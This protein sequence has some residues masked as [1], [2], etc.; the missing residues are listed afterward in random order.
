MSKDLRYFLKEVE[1]KQPEDFVRIKK[2]VDPKFELCGVIR[3]FQEEGRYPLVYFENVKNSEMP[4]VSNLFA[5]KSRL[6][7]GFGASE[8]TL[9][10]D[11]MT[12]EDK[13]IPSK[14]VSDGP[15][16]ENV[17]KGDDSISEILASHYSL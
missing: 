16:K 14:V 8:S 3:K 17:I 7:L 10:K 4:V 15:V 1:S 11:Y 12:N 9:L 13:R 2:Q 5:S 6:A